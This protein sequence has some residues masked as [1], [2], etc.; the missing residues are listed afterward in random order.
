MRFAL[1]T[2]AA[3]WLVQ[4]S[5][6]LGRRARS[7]LVDLAPSDLCIS[8]VT[9]SELARLLRTPFL[10]FTGD[11]LLI[12]ETFAQ[13]F[14]VQP[15]NPWIAHRAASYNWTHRDPADRHILATAEFLGLPLLTTDATVTPFAATIG[16]KIIW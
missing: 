10:Q 7:A 5:P 13:R 15:V 2:H 12:L 8:D 3:I 9:L 6:S 4:D 16:V 11:P 14:H 1:D